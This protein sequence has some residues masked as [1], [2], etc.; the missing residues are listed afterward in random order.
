MTPE[1]KPKPNV[2]IVDDV[3]TDLLLLE[4]MLKKLDVN[5]IPA[6][7]GAEAFSKIRDHEIALALLDIRM[8][9]MS[10]IE[11]TRIIRNDP[12]R[13]KVPIILISALT[14]ESCGLEKCFKSGEVD[15]ILKPVRKEVLLGKMQLFLDNYAENFHS[16]TSLAPS[17]RY[18]D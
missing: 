14:E 10:G 1:P 2:L 11:L 7:S 9:G 17:E 12:Y 8:P 15:F 18:P 5:L 3:A 16:A 4:T 6:R 13:E